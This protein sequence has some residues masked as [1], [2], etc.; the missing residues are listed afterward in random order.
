MKI[1]KPLYPIEDS[2]LPAFGGW[3]PG[4]YLCRCVHC[5]KQFFG[6]KRSTSCATCAY[7]DRQD[8]LQFLQGWEVGISGK[9]V[10]DLQFKTVD[11][12]AGFERGRLQRQE[13]LNFI[14]YWHNPLTAKG[15]SATYDTENPP[16]KN[17][18]TA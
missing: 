2:E 13:T 6:E 5:E 15:D 16:T 12:N 17:T 11:W 4:S 18:R 8:A 3:A 9:S 14:T 10:G 1:F 7:K